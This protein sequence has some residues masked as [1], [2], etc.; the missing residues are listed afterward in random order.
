MQMLLVLTEIPVFV[1]IDVVAFLFCKN[2]FPKKA[3]QNIC[4]FRINSWSVTITDIHGGSSWL[5]GCA[6]S[7]VIS[8][9]SKAALLDQY[10]LSFE[11]TI[12]QLYASIVAWSLNESEVG[13]NLILT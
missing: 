11:W 2:T 7:R 6:A 1:V 10:C 9:S 8:H 13:V 3:E 4:V 12:L 5:Y